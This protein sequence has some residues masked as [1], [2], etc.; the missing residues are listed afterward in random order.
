MS[1][2]SITLR[3]HVRIVPERL[4]AFRKLIDRQV[5]DRVVEKNHSMRVEFF[6]DESS[7]EAVFIESFADAETFLAD[8]TRDEDTDTTTFAETYEL[9]DAEVFGI[10][11]DEIRA[12]LGEVATFYSSLGVRQS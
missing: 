7:S 10:V 6:V 11:S 3:S 9:L 12:L 5:T 8:L 2:Q 1:Q 4:D